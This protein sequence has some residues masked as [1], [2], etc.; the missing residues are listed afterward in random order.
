LGVLAKALHVP[1]RLVSSMEELQVAIQD[2][3]QCN[4]IFI[5]TPSIPVKD[6]NAIKSLGHLLS[7]APGANIHY[8]ISCVSRDL[9]T[10]EQSRLYLKLR[11][12]SLMFS[13]MDESFSFG[14]IY[15]ISSRLGI[16]VTI[17]LSGKKVT[18]DWESATAERL[19]A[20]ILNIV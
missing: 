14:S 12:N 20:S 18:G 13:R 1:Y 17:F 2:L 6:Q 5:D 10:Y 19:A 11:P 7:A 8:V 15:S 4:R 16:P 9:E 3:S